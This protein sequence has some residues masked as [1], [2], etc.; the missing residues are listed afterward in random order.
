MTL[1]DTSVR[2]DHLRKPEELLAHLLLHDEVLM[3]PYVIGEIAL[4]NFSHR[5]DVLVRLATLPS[6]D[7]A[8]HGEVLSLVDD[9]GLF[10]TGLGYVDLHLVASARLMRGSTL[11]TR[12][13]RLHRIATRMELALRL[14]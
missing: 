4:G 12:D 1:I 6:A 5:K 14:N 7:M 9:E 10:G 8:R 11:W 2:I 13:K 3:H